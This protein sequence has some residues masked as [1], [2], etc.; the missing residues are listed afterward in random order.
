MR[1][2]A[3]KSGLLS[4]VSLTH[5]SCLKAVESF[6]D[7]GISFVTR[8]IPIFRWIKSFITCSTL[9]PEAGI[10]EAGIKELYG[11]YCFVFFVGGFLRSL[12][13][14]SWLLRSSANY[15]KAKLWFPWID[16]SSLYLLLV[17]SYDGHLVPFFVLWIRLNVWV[18]LIDTHVLEIFWVQ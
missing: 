4:G 8:F 11:N 18:A 3:A 2:V 13:D 7:H 14:V 6:H 1:K 12:N 15:W 5:W 9:L 10:C 17:L 16:C